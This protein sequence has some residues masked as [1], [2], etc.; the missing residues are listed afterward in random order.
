[1]EKLN[2]LVAN[3]RLSIKNLVK[4]FPRNIK[5]K[6][7][8]EPVIVETQPAEKKNTGFVM[9]RSTSTDKIIKEI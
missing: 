6:I 5:P 9:V 2:L 7:V 4:K 8:S 3:A 1:V